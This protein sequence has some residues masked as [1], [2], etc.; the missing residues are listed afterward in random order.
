MARENFNDLLAFLAVAQERSF[1]RAAARLGVS[2]SAL[3]HTI[4]AF[5][6]KLGVRLLTR[7]TRGVSPTAQGEQLLQATAPR[8]DE[9]RAELA[10]VSEL[11]DQPS[12]RLRITAT[13]YVIRTVLWPRLAPFLR[14]YPE[15]QV[16][17]ISDYRLTDIVAERFDIGVRLGDAIAKDMIAV[18]IA[19]DEQMAI[20]ATPGYFADH[21]K[22]RSP[23]DLADHC[24]IN[25]RTQTYDAIYAWE[26]EKNGRK[27][28]ARVEGQ[29]CFN[30]IYEIL[31][32][33]LDGFGLAYL[34][35]ELTR[36]HIETGHLIP[37][38][39]DWAP[40]FPGWHIYYPSRRQS[41]RALALLVEALRLTQ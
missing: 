8:I 15:I 34:P 14:A 19:P 32:A 4:R 36:P 20:V 27:L 7:T 30:G 33:A 16:E 37:V 21:P 11:G 9:I 24:C 28:Q 39:T 22:P 18:R 26:L 3:S 35:Y 25:L 2:Q 31:H 6:A 41:S 12:G 13:D 38:L 10:A 23:A 1:T 5:E 17:C 29:L 40:S